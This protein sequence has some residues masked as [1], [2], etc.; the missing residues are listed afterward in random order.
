[1]NPQKELLWGLWVFNKIQR[2][3]RFSFSTR[4][5]ACIFP[6]QTSRA[7][8]YRG[9]LCTK[10]PTA[11][12]TLYQLFALQIELD[13]EPGIELFRNPLETCVEN[14]KRPVGAKETHF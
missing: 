11:Y 9:M 14:Q 7:K 2:S 3:C 4:Y 8:S 1:M 13:E 6:I 12:K 5:A 10:K